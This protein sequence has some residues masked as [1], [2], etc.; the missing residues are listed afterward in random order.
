[1]RAILLLENRVVLS[2]AL[3][4]LRGRYRLLATKNNLLEEKY[5]IF[6]IDV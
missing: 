6:S 3:G 2:S 4:V 1:M 5:V